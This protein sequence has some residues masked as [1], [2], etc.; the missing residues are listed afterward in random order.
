MKT[1]R[2]FWSYLAQFFLEQEMFQRKVIEKIKTHV[3]CSVPFLKNSNC[4]WDNVDKYC[5]ARQATDD[6]IIKRTACRIPKA[7]NTYQQYAIRIAFPLQW[8]YE[9][10]SMLRH[11]YTVC[12]VLS[13]NTFNTRI[14]QSTFKSLWSIPVKSFNQNVTYCYACYVSRPY[15]PLFI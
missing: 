5:T 12:L 3:L 1:N 9:S 2:W 7:I 4:L 15:T 13:A 6:S 8:L 14:I 10:P 11:M